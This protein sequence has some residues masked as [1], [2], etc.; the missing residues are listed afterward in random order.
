MPTHTFD[1][2]VHLSLARSDVFAFFAAAG[3][4]PRIT[5]PKMKFRVLTAEPIVI[6]Q[7]SI[8][9]YS[10]RVFGVSMRWRSLISRWNPPIE[11]VDEQ[12]QGPYARWT[13][14][15]RFRDEAG[16]TKIED[17]VEYELPYRLLGELAHPLVRRQLEQI[18][19]YRQQAIEQILLPIKSP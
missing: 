8:I 10:V 11:F 1:S 3:N 5:P 14:W 15:H 4:L 7:G 6:H 17:H 19:G 18:F 13:H 16:G 12:L 9:D 2:S